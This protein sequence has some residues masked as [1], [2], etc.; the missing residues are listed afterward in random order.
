LYLIFRQVMAWLGLLARGAHSKNAEILV[1]RQPVGDVFEVAA[2]VCCRQPGDSLV[3]QVVRETGFGVHGLAHHLP[4]L[5]V[6]RCDDRAGPPRP[7]P[8]GVP[9]WDC[10]RP[11]G[12]EPRR[13]RRLRSTFGLPPK[14][15]TPT[16]A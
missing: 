8:A 5:A 7:A 9:T 10:R 2:H 16:P 14:R 4:D 3:E 12:A 1:L 15:N 13:I 11:V 6:E